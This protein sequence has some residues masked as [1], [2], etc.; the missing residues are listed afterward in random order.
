MSQ[1]IKHLSKYLLP[2]AVTGVTTIG[3]NI[4]VAAQVSAQISLVPQEEGEIFLN[5]APGT[6]NGGDFS[7]LPA[8]A[9]DVNNCID[10][11]DSTSGLISSVVSLLDDTTGEQ[12]RLFV[13]NLMTQST[14]NGG[15]ISFAAGDA[16]T[17]PEGFWFRPS[18]VNEENGQLEVGTFRFD[19][20]QVIPELTIFYF[21]TERGNNTGVP[22]NDSLNFA[23]ATVLQTNGTLISGDN[24]I[25]AGEDSNISFQVWQNVNFIT[26]KLGFDNPNGSRTGDG[27]D[28]QIVDS[29]DDTSPQGGEPVPEPL[30]ILGSAAAVGFGG[31]FKKKLAKSSKKKNQS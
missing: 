25:L 15:A 8:L 5:N 2:V 29:T 22:T 4:L 9:G 27:V 31:L 11:S 16:G 7:C 14:Y 1:I 10:L 18:E 3:V 24:P 30:T 17:N 19:F 28:F 26:L 13:D 12:S 20:A 6:F 21:D 23:D